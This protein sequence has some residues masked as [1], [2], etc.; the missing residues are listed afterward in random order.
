MTPINRAYRTKLHSGAASDSADDEG[1]AFC[2]LNYWG[3][4]HVHVAL[5][6]ALCCLSGVAVFT[7]V[8]GWCPD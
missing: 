8:G 1:P 6:F 7:V 4:V 5:L 3:A 2:F